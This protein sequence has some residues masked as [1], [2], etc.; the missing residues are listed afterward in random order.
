MSD[1]T[2]ERTIQAE[3]ADRLLRYDVEIFFERGI[4]RRYSFEDYEGAETVLAAIEQYAEGGA[5]A[6]RS[7]RINYGPGGAFEAVIILA[8]V[9]TATLS[10][11]D[12]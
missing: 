11:L 9:V 12:Y 6:K 5:L 4:I 8:K 7:C 1:G 10:L 3:P 2:E